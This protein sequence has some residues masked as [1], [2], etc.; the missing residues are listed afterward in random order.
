MILWTEKWAYLNVVTSTFV[1]RNSFATYANLG[2]LIALGLIAEAFLAVRSINDFRRVGIEL[3]KKLLGPRGILIFAFLLLI[4]AMLLTGSRGGLLSFFGAA[5]FLLFLVFLVMR[6]KIRTAL[7]TLA[8]VLVLAGGLLALSGGLTLS[9][10][11]AVDTDANTDIS[12]AGRFSIWQVAFGMIGQRPWLGHGYGSFLDMFY[13]SRDDRFTVIFDMAHDTYI[14]H[15]VELGIPATVLLYTGPLLLFGMCVR[16]VFIR[17]RDQ[18]VPLVGA[19][20][21]V[22]VGLHSLVDF[23]LQIPAVAVTY[24]AIL[25][26]GCAQ[27]MRSEPTVKPARSRAV[28]LPVPEPA[29]SA[30][31]RAGGDPA[32]PPRPRAGGDPSATP[33]PAGGTPQPAEA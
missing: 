26:A 13:V 29:L 12:S 9:R 7:A 23:S 6:P 33:P 25:G 19:S 24:A 16:G 2:I 3:T 20:A 17:R 10:L 22:L 21:T 11:D 4:T 27:A 1:N 5:A 18:V 8:V 32:L 30:H 31:P 28:P 15:L 14:E